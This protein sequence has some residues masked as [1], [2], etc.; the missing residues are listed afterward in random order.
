[1]TPSVGEEVETP[2]GRLRVVAIDRDRETVHLAPLDWQ[3]EPGGRHDPL[4]WPEVDY[5]YCGFTAEPA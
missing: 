5:A 2:S 4:D 3:H 1:M